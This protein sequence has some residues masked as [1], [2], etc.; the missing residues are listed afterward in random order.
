VCTVPQ[1]HD[2]YDAQSADIDAPEARDHHDL[3]ILVRGRLP[4]HL[5][6]AAILPFPEA[7]DALLDPTLD[8]PALVDDVRHGVT[9][10]C[11][12]RPGGG[13]VRPVR[14]S[15]SSGPRSGSA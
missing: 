10:Q 12:G 8:V 15:A 6:D 13:R 9:A 5:Q 11:R 1:E 14:G 2:D 7:L 3:R 4:G